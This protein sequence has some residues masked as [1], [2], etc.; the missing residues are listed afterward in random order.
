MNSD[1]TPYNSQVTDAIKAKFY[2]NEIIS[3]KKGIIL[4]SQKI[5]IFIQ[6]GDSRPTGGEA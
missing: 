4:G 3:I 5:T 6:L 1:S 2:I